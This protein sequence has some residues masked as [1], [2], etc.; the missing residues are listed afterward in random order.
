MSVRPLRSSSASAAVSGWPDAGATAARA[1]SSAHPRRSAVQRERKR[2][3]S[4]SAG[5]TFL[6]DDFRALAVPGE[7]RSSKYVAQGFERFEI[8]DGALELHLREFSGV[9]AIA[10]NRRE[11]G[12]PLE[13]LEEAPRASTPSSSEPAGQRADP[14]ETRVVGRRAR[15]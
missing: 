1:H 12:F 14:F 4:A 6:N 2:R 13:P 15:R 8:L 10:V 5:L 9:D 11:P 3:R 7:I